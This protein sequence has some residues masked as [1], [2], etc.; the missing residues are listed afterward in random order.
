MD[1][2]NFE[3]YKKLFK[4]SKTFN[5]YGPLRM[6]SKQSE[7]TDPKSEYIV[8]LIKYLFDEYIVCEFKVKNTLDSVF[9][10]NL[11]RLLPMCHVILR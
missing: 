11:Y 4:E 6:I 2:E 10:Y 9:Q 3:K 1:L 8:T 7:L 5:E